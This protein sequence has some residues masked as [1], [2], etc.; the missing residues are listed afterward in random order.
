MYYYEDYVKDIESLILANK[1]II[2]VIDKVESYDKR[3]IFAL[4]IGKGK[5]CGIV[6]A[7]VHGREY[8]N[9]PALMK[10]VKEYIRNYNQ[11]N[12]NKTY[13]KDLLE[14]NSL[15]IVP[16]L[17]PDGYE[18][19]LKGYEVIKNEKLK[20][21]CMDKNIDYKEW[22]YNARCID[23]NRNFSSLSWNKKY[24][25]DYPF[26]EIET[27]FMKKIFDKYYGGLYIDIHSRGENINYYRKYLDEKYNKKQRKIADDISEFT[28]YRISEPYEEINVGDS[29]GNTVHYY[30]EKYRCPA[31]TIETV[32]ENEI[33]PLKYNN[34]DIIYNKLYK[35]LG[36]IICVANT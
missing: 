27:R 35:L 7:G 20:K 9:T 8:V 1:E 13:K 34:V 2:D 32:D 6:S 5:A 19:A 11:C 23:I 10:I 26:S 28:K 31:I 15:I 18:I 4:K 16:L 36:Y 24:K 30:S 29:G 33:F 21:I 22:K 17:N 3:T 25:S 14:N 12:N